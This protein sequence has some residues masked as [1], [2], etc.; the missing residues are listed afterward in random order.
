MHY[1]AL[2]TSVLLFNLGCWI[3]LKT[4]TSNIQVENHWR[5][6]QISKSFN[7]VN[8]T[9]IRL[10][11]MAVFW[12]KVG[13]IR[14]YRSYLCYIYAFRFPL[15][16]LVHVISTAPQSSSGHFPFLNISYGAE[17]MVFVSA[18]SLLWYHYVIRLRN[19]SHEWF[20][21]PTEIICKI[22]RREEND[23]KILM[24]ITKA[25]VSQAELAIWRSPAA[26]SLFAS[27]PDIVSDLRL[28]LELHLYLQFT[29]ERQQ[30]FHFCGTFFSASQLQYVCG[31]INSQNALITRTSILVIAR[32]G[33]RSDASNNETFCKF[34]LA[35]VESLQLYISGDLS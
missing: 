2:K 6:F 15:S 32:L 25:A 4:E 19:L 7:S 12:A 22:E 30:Y 33:P 20:L 18:D 23:S 14:R 26:M 29:C 9:V 1:F 34:Y 24:L 17:R 10:F 28:D 35:A 8:L 13:Q 11:N 3:L 5:I 16:S 27:I 31:S 21:S